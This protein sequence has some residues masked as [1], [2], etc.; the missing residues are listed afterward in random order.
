MEPTADELR[1]NLILGALPPAD[2]ERLAGHLSLVD[3]ELRS[4]LHEA[5]AGID[6]V[7]FPLVGV[8][9]L[10]TD[11]GGGTVVEVATI[12]YEGMVGLPVFLRAGP[13]AERAAVQVAGRALAMSAERFRHDVAVLD[14]CLQLAMQRFTQV[15]FTQLARN[16]ACNRSH[17]LR[18]RCARWL[19]M[20]ADRMRG[21]TFEL[22]Q[23]FLAQML[24]VRRASVSEI[25]GELQAEGCISYRRG[26][27]VIEDRAALESR[28]C[29]CYV[30]VRDAVRAAYATL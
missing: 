1:S 25:A 9:S 3:L 12:G 20:T 21:E 27:I 19:L 29:D 13:P 10:V 23:E 17:S 6:Q 28:S 30:I 11:V 15:M 18:R 16:A 5:G 4:V 7:Y 2:R 26:T 8:V 22:T 14:G 24:G